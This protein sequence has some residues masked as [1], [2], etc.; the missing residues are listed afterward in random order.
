METVV[1]EHEASILAACVSFVIPNS[2]GG[3]RQTNAVHDDITVRMYV[4]VRIRGDQTALD[5]ASRAGRDSKYNTRDEGS[6]LLRFSFFAAQ[7][8][9]TRLLTNLTCWFEA[10]ISFTCCGP[11]LVR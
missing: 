2:A 9:Q 8:F 4:C 6:A 11:G 5:D 3:F 1:A 7:S 10:A